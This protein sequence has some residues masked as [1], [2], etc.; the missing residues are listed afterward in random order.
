MTA[1]SNGI[2]KEVRTT[3]IASG[4]SLS[5]AVDLHGLIVREIGLP[6]TFDGTAITF[7]ASIDGT[8][9]FNL[10]DEAGTEVNFP[11]GASRIITVSNAWLFTGIVYLKI[12]AGTA[13]SA[14]NQSTTDTVITITA[15]SFD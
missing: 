6:A 4:A 13:A 10:Y 11:A 9:Y 7:Q 3:T 2:I 1:L 8:N 15:V 12:R 5:A 14:T